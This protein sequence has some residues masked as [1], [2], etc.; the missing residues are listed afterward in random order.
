LAVRLRKETTM[1]VETGVTRQQ[2][3]EARLVERARA[4]LRTFV[5]LDPAVRSALAAEYY[6]PDATAEIPPRG[7][8]QLYASMMPD[9]V[10]EASM[11]VVHMIQSGPRVLSHVRMQVHRVREVDGE[12]VEQDCRAD[13]II[14]LEFEGGLVVKSWS[15]LR[16]R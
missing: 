14:T 8:C 3:A 12:I 6:A 15:V 11:E 10:R 7:G 2:Q 16:W 9:E 5:E 1:V 4:A 13:G